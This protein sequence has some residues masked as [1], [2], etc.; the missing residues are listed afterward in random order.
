MKKTQIL[1][2]LNLLALL[3]HVTLAYFTQFKVINDQDVGQV[4]D[5]Y[6]SIFTPAGITFA[7][8]GVIYTALLF[9]CIYHIRMAFNQTYTHPAN[10]N[11]QRI[12]AWFILN[13]ISA[14]AWL[15]VWTK[16]LIIASMCLII[17]QLITLIII[18]LR[19]NIHDPHSKID[20]KLFTQ[21]PLSIY[22]GWLTIATIANVS[23]YLLASGWR[24]FGLDYSPIEW[25]RIMIGI[26]VFLCVAVVFARRNVIFGLVIVWALYGIILKR[27]SVNPTIYA[28]VIKTAWV[29]LGIVGASCM[30]Q[31]LQNIMAKKDLS[32]FTQT[33]FP[34]K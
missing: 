32:S 13:N 27:E 21:F 18:N 3:I 30:I 7:I 10:Q 22:F 23:V 17:F 26:A 6:D 1:A 12:G 19:L 28:D 20:S 15:L 24:G 16:G 4:S 25:T 2:I 29:G 11:V 33:T 34:A 5:A 9:F 14:A 8:W 31:F